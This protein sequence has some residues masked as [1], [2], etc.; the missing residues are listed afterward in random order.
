MV[1][2]AMLAFL[3]AP[4][5]S[6]ALE[7]AE[8]S[9]K[10]TMGRYVYSGGVGSNDINLR[11]SSDAGN[12][13]VGY[14]ESAQRA[15]AQLRGGWDHTFELA[16]VRV[17]PSL[18]AASMGFSSLSVQAETGESWFVGAGLGRTNLRPYSNL[19]FDPNDSWTASFGK[20]AASG[21]VFYL[22]QVRDNRLNPDQRH[23]HAYYRMPLD[24][25]DRI[26]LD[27]LY[28]TGLVNDALIH[29][30][31]LSVAYDWPKFF[32]SAAYDPKVNFSTDNMLR[33]S[34]GVRF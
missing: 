10:L 6:F 27:L 24:N 32:I 15:E 8:P 31:G 4:S 9:Y 23:I 5:I 26:T 19:N 34:I 13:W 30:W 2:I 11:N 20:R 12:L 14:Y 16:K 1:R 7:S 33:T 25:G 18:Q 28:K 21:E 17:S 3:L 22:Q 29:K